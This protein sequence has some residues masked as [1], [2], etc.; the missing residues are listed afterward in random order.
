VASSTFAFE[1]QASIERY[2]ETGE[3]YVYSRYG[4][5]TVRETERFLADLEGAEAAACFGSGMAAITT[6]FLSWAKAGD[7]VAAQRELYGGTVEF[8]EALS[9]DMGIDVLWLDRNDMDRLEPETLRDCRVL[10]LE[11]P[12][13]PALRIVDL[14]RV[15]GV[16]R[17]AGAVVA[18]D[19]TFATP[20]L[21]RPLSYGVDLVLHSATKY[22]GGHGDLIGGVVAGRA[23]LID[24]IS[25]RRRILGGTLDPF[26]AFLLHRGMR[27]LAVRMEAHS[28]GAAAV[29][30]FLEDH[31]KVER[32]L[33]PGL[34]SHPDHALAGRQMTGFGGMVSFIVRGGAPGAE[35]LH[36]EVELFARAGSLGGTES[37]I[38]IPAR[39]SHRGL[40]PD[41]RVEAGVPDGMVRLSVGLES[42]DDLVADL[43]RSL[44]RVDV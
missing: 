32:V 24:R 23:E 7:R 4:N 13:N 8:L 38:S 20:A 3:G 17:R 30:A 2:Y 21:Q 26:S 10:Y 15:S 34:P 9:S 41:A 44:D 37:L 40:D 1:D 31:P 35:M 14:E 42:P 18:V 43:E 5:P 29:A 19:G 12:T 39:M 27:T 22:L 33:Y 28:R 11:T 16:G 36:D 25:H 6:T